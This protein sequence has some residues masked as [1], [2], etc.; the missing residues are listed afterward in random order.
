[1]ADGGVPMSG[2]LTRFSLRQ[3]IEHSS[4][5]LLFTVLA[6]TGLAQKYFDAGWAAWVIAALGGIDRVRWIHRASGILFTGFALEHAGAGLFAVAR[7]RGQVFIVPTRK[8]FQ[9]AIVTLRYYLRLSDER[10]SFD[11]YDYRQ[12]FEYWGLVLGGTI[13]TVTGFM[14]LFPVEV[15]RFLPGELIPAA[16]IIHGYEG[17]LAFLVVITWHVYNAHLS[18]DVFPFDASIFTGKMSRERMEKEHPLELRRLAS[19]DAEEPEKRKR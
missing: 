13:M 7:R 12:K 14:L 15:T 2:T 16:K 3:R 5:M 18:P 1:M 4:V 10:A 8:D 11:R 6:V 19:K 17:L 9:D